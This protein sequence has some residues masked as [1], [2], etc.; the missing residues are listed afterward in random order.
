M[1]NEELTLLIPVLPIEIQQITRIDLQRA[2]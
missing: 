1:V 2:W